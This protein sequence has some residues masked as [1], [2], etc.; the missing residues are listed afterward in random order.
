METQNRY[1]NEENT[2][3]KS[4]KKSFEDSFGESTLLK[5]TQYLIKKIKNWF[6]E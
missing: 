3:T 1:I 5:K 6:D 4:N 2:E